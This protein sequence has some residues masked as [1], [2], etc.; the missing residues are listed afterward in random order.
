MQSYSTA[1]KD[2]LKL[3]DQKQLDFEELSAYLSSVTSEHDRI[4]AGLPPGVG[5]G[6]YFKSKIEAMRGT[7][8]GRDS[9]AEK[10]KGKITEVGCFY[11][12]YG[13]VLMNSV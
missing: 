5:L 6:S 4:I 11:L 1:L 8:I 9:R 3:R 13:H 7:D 2:V 12:C 10:L